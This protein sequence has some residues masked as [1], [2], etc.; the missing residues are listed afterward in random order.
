MLEVLGSASQDKLSLHVCEPRA[1]GLG[2]SRWDAASLGTQP[3]AGLPVAVADRCVP[4]MYLSP[5]PTRA[6]QGLQGEMAVGSPHSDHRV[7][8]LRKAAFLKNVI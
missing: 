8:H 5:T 4:R 6:V 2:T 7:R 3:R 1:T